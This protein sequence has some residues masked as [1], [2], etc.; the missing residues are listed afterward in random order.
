MC[1]CF[2]VSEVEKG[3]L[4]D[5]ASLASL[6]GLYDGWL[7]RPVSSRWTFTMRKS[8]LEMDRPEACF[9]HWSLTL[10]LSDK[11]ERCWRRWIA[12][13]WSNL[14]QPATRGSAMS[15]CLP[16]R[17]HWTSVVLIVGGWPFVF[18][19]GEKGISLGMC[20]NGKWGDAICWFDVRR[21]PAS[22]RLLSCD[23]S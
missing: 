9:C 1:V 6:V 12:C 22:R 15:M 14:M 21:R 16:F 19:Y 18:H 13:R 7:G 11:R 17:R 5:V 4:S 20:E 23:G 2:F 10:S 3:L 8:R